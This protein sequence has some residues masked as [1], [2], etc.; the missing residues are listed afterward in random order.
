MMI[1]P[2]EDQATAEDV[3]RI[4][5]AVRDR[6]DALADVMMAELAKHIGAYAGEERSDLRQDV[7]AHCATHIRLFL[8]AASTGR[9]VP[10]NELPF[11]P[12]TAAQRVEQGVS[13]ESVLQAFRIGQRCVWD[14]ILASAKEATTGAEAALA[15]AGPSMDY[16]DAVSSAVADAYLRAQQAAI[17]DEDRG[18]RDLLGEILD[19]RVPLSGAMRAR[20]VSYGLEPPVPYLVAVATIR[21]GASHAE[22]RQVS[23]VIQDRAGEVCRGVLLVARRDELVALMA[24]RGEDLRP[25]RDALSSS[26]ARLGEDRGVTVAVGVS[27][28]AVGLDAAPLAYREA[29]RAL[30]WAQPGPGMVALPFV[31]VFDYLV[32]NA[33]DTARRIPSLAD[34]LMGEEAAK[35]AVARETLGSYFDSGLNVRKAA[36][37]LGIHAN[38]MHYRLRGIAEAT[39]CDLHDFRS[40]V[41]LLV[42]LR[43]REQPL[44]MAVDASEEL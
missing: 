31:S 21:E 8:D 15:L 44:G 3:V 34:P 41:E 24:P 22:Q 38:T 12:E 27:T 10:T 43:L 39:D 25:L 7:R 17:A 14:A 33:D 2:K 11:L 30:S 23:R 1:E 40:L 5:A 16:I 20:A 32:A 13:L 6:E 28:V 18:R 26:I 35:L 29:Q 19:G 37:C 42:G 36:E 9:P 4:I